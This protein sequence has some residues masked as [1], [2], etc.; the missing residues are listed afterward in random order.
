MTGSLISLTSE[1]VN[2]S[3]LQFKEDVEMVFEIYQQ[4][5]LS[6]F[7]NTGCGSIYYYL[8]L[9]GILSES[10]LSSICVCLH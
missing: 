1:W 3:L 7:L 6:N 5:P 4:E 8:Y 9:F 10:N 2:Y